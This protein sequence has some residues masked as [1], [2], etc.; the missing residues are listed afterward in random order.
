MLLFE[1][2]F[3]DVRFLGDLEGCDYKKGFCINNQSEKLIVT[4]SVID[5]MSVMTNFTSAGKRLESI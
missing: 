2:L 1:A 5:A 3:Q 4:E